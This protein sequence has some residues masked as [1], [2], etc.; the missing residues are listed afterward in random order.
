MFLNGR[1][2]EI[3]SPA[4][5]IAL[6]VEYVSEDRRRHGVIGEMAVASNVTLS[7]LQA[8]ARAGLIN[9]NAERT[10]ASRYVR[11]LGVKTPSAETSVASLSGGNQQKV[12]LARALAANPSVLILDEP[13]Q[14]VDV[15]SK[16]EI[17][18]LMQALVEQGL[19]ILMIS[20]ELPEVL[21]MSDRVA[22]MRGGT[23]AGVLS[24]AEASQESVMALALGQVG[25]A[26]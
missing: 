2:A 26:C 21:G 18:A 8:V 15:G 13:T 4:Q 17:H 9:N 5:A 23:I 14:G 11:E 10:V 6:G 19:A 3:A 22:V 24:R 7:S 12:M 1:R 25:Q 16:S 20:S